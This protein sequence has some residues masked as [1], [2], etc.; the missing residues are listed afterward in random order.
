[1]MNAF[2]IVLAEHWQDSTLQVVS[3]NCSPS[4]CRYYAVHIDVATILAGLSSQ[5]NYTMSFPPLN[6]VGSFN[7]SF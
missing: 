7:P 1:M 6:H 5:V 3:S 4:M 2:R